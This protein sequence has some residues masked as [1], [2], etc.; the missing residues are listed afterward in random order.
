MAFPGLYRD[1][2]RGDFDANLL[3]VIDTT[4][5]ACRR[6]RIH[7]TG[8]PQLWAQLIAEFIYFFLIPSRRDGPK[9]LCFK[10]DMGGKKQTTSG[11]SGSSPL[12]FHEHPIFHASDHPKSICLCRSS[13]PSILNAVITLW[14]ASSATL[15]VLCRIDM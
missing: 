4:A 5:I 10:P 15:R 7:Q 8:G 6:S 11:A 12:R 1:A 9:S 3:A 2:V 14:R 13:L